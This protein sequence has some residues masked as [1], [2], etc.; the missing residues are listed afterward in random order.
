MYNEGLTNHYG[1]NGASEAFDA[2]AYAGAPVSSV[3]HLW[4]NS[5]LSGDNKNTST[6]NNASRQ[7]PAGK[8]N[9]GGLITVQCNGS[10]KATATQKDLLIA[11]RTGLAT[12]IKVPGFNANCEC[13]KPVCPSCVIR[14]LQLA[15]VDC[16]RLAASAG[17]AVLGQKGCLRNKIEL[18]VDVPESIRS[19]IVKPKKK[20]TRKRKRN[21]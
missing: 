8:A 7:A 9:G 6:N 19:T 21:R 4:L 18:L 1:Y 15:V 3:G 10:V 20:K 13:D 12:A 2:R 16:A 5:T 17:L 11:V 14:M